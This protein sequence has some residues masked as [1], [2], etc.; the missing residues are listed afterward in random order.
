M[1]GTTFVLLV[2]AGR[3]TGQPHL[4][5]AMVMSWNPSTRSWRSGPVN[6]D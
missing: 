4:M 5:T 6:T 1:L 3:K 2:H